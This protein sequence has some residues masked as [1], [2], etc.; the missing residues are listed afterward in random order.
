[1]GG[2]AANAGDAGHPRDVGATLAPPNEQLLE[3]PTCGRDFAVRLLAPLAIG[4]EL[5]LENGVHVRQSDSHFGRC[6]M[7][8]H[9]VLIL[10]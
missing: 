9:S 5:L 8:L 2:V 6:Q 7:I 10:R 4:A 3:L 1:M